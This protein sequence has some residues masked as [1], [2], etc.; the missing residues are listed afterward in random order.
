MKKFFNK[1]NDYKYY[2]AAAATTQL[3]A[4]GAS[5]QSAGDVASNVESS[6]RQIASLVIA[7]AFL[8]GIALVAMGLFRLKAAVDT[9][10]QQVK[11]SE[12]LWRLAL[13]AALVAL[14]AVT[15]VG[16]T[17]FFGSNESGNASQL[18]SLFD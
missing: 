9:Q 13:G 1:I 4:T 2:V 8:G 7:G 11:Y 5:A 15:G 3:M 17:T 12:G 18:E 6:V 16:V 14:P 10:G